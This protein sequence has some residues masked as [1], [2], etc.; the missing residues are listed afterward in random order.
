MNYGFIKD[1]VITAPVAMCS[2]FNG[3]GAWHTLTDE[4]RAE[5]GWYPCEVLN[6]SVNA[7][8]AS[9]S[10]LP[11]LAF[12]GEKI[13]AVYTVI[14]K[15]LETIKAELVAALAAYRF[16]REEGG[17]TLADGVHIATDRESKS[18]LNKTYVELKNGLIP[19]TDWK[20]TPDWQLRDLA[21]FEPIAKA[22]AAHDRA[23]FRGE[24]LVQGMINN[25]LGIPVLELFN[26]GNLFDAAYQEAYAE[27]MTP[28]QAPE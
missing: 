1:G 14:D 21:Q 2:V 13:T 27:V 26:I 8:T 15:S 16:S 17:L 28:E 24:R 11:E 3:I 25:A 22:L 9:R 23:C 18:Q 19:D 12:D 20:Y 5:Q 10:E 7:L 4:T 6:E